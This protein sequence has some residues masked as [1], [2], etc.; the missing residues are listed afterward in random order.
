MESKSMTMSIS[1]VWT[2]L[3]D[4][5]LVFVQGGQIDGVV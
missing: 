5:F 2:G 1:E 3:A 4:Q